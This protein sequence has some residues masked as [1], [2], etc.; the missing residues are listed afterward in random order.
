MKRAMEHWRAARFNYFKNA[1]LSAAPGIKIQQVTEK[2]NGLEE[3]STKMLAEG[4]DDLRE[5]GE[6]YDEL[7]RYIEAGHPE[8]CVHAL[9]M[10]QEIALN[11]PVAL[12]G[13]G[14]LR[15]QDASRKK[16]RALC[17]IGILP[18]GETTLTVMAAARSHCDAI[19]L[20]ANKM[21]SGFG[22][23]HAMESWMVYGSDHWFI[24]PSAWEAIPESRRS[25]ILKAIISDD[26]NIGDVPPFSILDDARRTVIGYVREHIGET[27]DYAAA[28]EQ[29]AIE[30]AKLT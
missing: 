7:F 4:E 14:V 2:G 17:L 1:I 29:L 27:D 18:Q 13:L 6:L 30:E 24:R 26:Y 11:I 9:D 15:Y 5:L 16:H 12:S 10:C 23:L 19:E 20:F 25:L 21:L 22:A 8:P 28:L 3:A